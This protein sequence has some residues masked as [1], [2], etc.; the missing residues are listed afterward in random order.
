[1][2]CSP[3][4]SGEKSLNYVKRSLHCGR[5]DDT[6]QPVISTPMFFC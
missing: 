4:L 5:E 6:S 3:E 2:K 1:M